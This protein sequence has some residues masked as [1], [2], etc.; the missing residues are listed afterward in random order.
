[1]NLLKTVFYYIVSGFF[2]V[3]FTLYN[4]LEVRGIENIPDGRQVIVASNHASN[5]DP[6][7]IGGVFPGRLRYLAKE[8]LFRIPL[9]GFF[10]S[11]LGAIPV[12]RED[13]QRAGVVIRIMLALL[14]EGRSILIFPEGTR[15]EGGELRR[16]EAGVA[17]MS[18]KS[19][20]PVLPAYIGGSHKACQKGRFIPR[21]V[22]I[23]VTFSRPI[24]PI[25]GPIGEREKRGRLM[26]EIE[27]ELS[28]MGRAVAP[29][30]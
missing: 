2:R 29:R 1:M 9:L 8:S 5:A 16:L 21:P 12:A 25:E 17:M 23:T 26:E 18:V 4:R 3:F 13:S 30:D 6:L 22:K 20:V 10:V 15:S 11:V 24:Y 7:I 28:A 19:G 14:K 27:S